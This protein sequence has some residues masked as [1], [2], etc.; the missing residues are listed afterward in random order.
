MAERLEEC[1]VSSCGLCVAEEEISAVLKCIM[2][3]GDAFFLCLGFKVD[4]EVAAYDQV[5]ARKGRVGE[6]VLFGEYHV[7]P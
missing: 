6:E 1:A 3:E 2:K 5:E 4:Q 7:L